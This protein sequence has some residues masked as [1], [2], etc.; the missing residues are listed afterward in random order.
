MISLDSTGLIAVG[1]IAVVLV[2]LAI[3]VTALF[4]VVSKRMQRKR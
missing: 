2:A 3:G 4:A 1:V